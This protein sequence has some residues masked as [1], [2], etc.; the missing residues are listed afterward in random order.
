MRL[1]ISLLLACALI[2]ASFQ[3]H[4]ATTMPP[5]KNRRLLSHESNGND[6]VFLSHDEGTSS[7]QDNTHHSYGGADK[8]VI[9][10]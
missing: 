2:L 9:R 6:V 7:G 5:I 3:A 8:P 4:A 1:V 10:H